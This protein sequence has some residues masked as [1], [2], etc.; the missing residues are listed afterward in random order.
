MIRGKK[1]LV[2][3]AHHDDE[4]LGCGATMAKLSRFNEI[5]VLIVTDS[6]TSQYKSNA[7]E[8]ISKKK[9]ASEEVK[10]LLGVKKYF[11]ADLPDMGLDTIKSTLLND[12]IR[13][14]IIKTKANVVFTHHYG[15]INKDHRM[16][17]ESSL[18]ATRPISNSSY[19][20]EI[21]CYEVLSSSEWSFHNKDSFT[22][23]V[24]VD[25][26]DYISVKE[27]A[28]GIYSTEIKEYP[29]P[30]SKKGIRIQAQKRG[31][32]VGMEYAECFCLL[33]KTVF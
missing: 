8:M 18:V 11:F 21:Y 5:N 19:V 28:M 14:H 20:E 2:V 1:I 13:D 26:H 10:K 23:N 15:D 25:I 16:I 24:W 6:C 9:K 7:E 4:V 22:P 32:E 29:H 30:R 12:T 3:A 33:R 27:K 17:F 31:L